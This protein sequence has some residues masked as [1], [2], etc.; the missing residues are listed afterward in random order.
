MIQCHLYA[1]LVSDILY[2]TLFSIRIYQQVETCVYYNICM[3]DDFK[4][5]SLLALQGSV[6]RRL[7]PPD[8]LCQH[9]QGRF[10]LCLL[11]TTKAFRRKCHASFIY[12][13]AGY[14]VERWPRLDHVVRYGILC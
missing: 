7:C 11:V 9:R 6:G 13:E 8:L 2:S 12:T 4:N 3:K 1:S 5:Q 10:L 14:G